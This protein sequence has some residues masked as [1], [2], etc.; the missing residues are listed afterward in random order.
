MDSESLQNAALKVGAHVLI[1]LGSE[2]VTDVEQ[3]ILEC[4]KNSYDADAPGC[5]IDIDTQVESVTEETGPASK[6]LRFSSSNETVTVEFVDENGD[7][8]DCADSVDNDKVLTR[9]LHYVGRLTIE[10]A[11][12]GLQP[13]Q[14]LDSWLVV[15]RSSKRGK[16]GERKAKTQLGRT[17][18]RRQGLRPPRVNEAW[19]CS[20][21]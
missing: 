14:I 4:V 11:G 18:H 15:S 19:R 6:L 21:H 9:R 2:L 13:A 1:Q 16:L 17:P 20:S 7:P 5:T 8:V 10:D 3:A 12:D